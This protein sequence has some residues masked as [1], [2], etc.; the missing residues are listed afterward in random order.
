MP[1]TTARQAH[2]K[3][4][5]QQQEIAR[6]NMRLERALSALSAQAALQEDDEP[7]RREPSAP[8]AGTA[9]SRG[10]P[11]EAVGVQCSLFVNEQER[12]RSALAREYEAKVAAQNEA[13]ALRRELQTKAHELADVTAML[14][15][16]KVAA[17][18]QD[19]DLLE[20]QHLVKQLETQLEVV[21]MPGCP[22]AKGSRKAA[23][24]KGR[25]LERR[26]SFPSDGGQSS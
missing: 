20:K 21:D 17:A 3:R 12:Q 13:E 4:K 25:E 10:G 9:T 2:E 16:A 11:T 1:N 24:E 18:Q 19:A 15:E 6:L 26:I 14:I 22:S 5:Q 7:V 23:K 8:P